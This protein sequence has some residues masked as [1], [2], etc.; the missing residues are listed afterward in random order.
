MMVIF[1][2]YL[3]KELIVQGK[4][5]HLFENPMCASASLLVINKIV[6]SDPELFISKGFFPPSQE[7]Q[8]EKGKKRVFP[9]ASAERNSFFSSPITTETTDSD[10]IPLRK[11]PRV[12]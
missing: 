9:G 10:D 11:K 2:I 3:N 4:A 12:L 8:E 6:P 5:N 7:A 1:G